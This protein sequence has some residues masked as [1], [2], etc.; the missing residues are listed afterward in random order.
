LFT[1][2]QKV[3]TLLLV[4]V[5]NEAPFQQ[6]GLDFIGEI[7]PHSSAQQ[8]WIL[9]ATEYFSKWVEAIPTRNA[10]DAIVISFLE[11]NILSR[12]GC[13]QKIVTDN[14]QAFNSMSM[15]SFC[16]KYNIVLGHS[17]D[18]YPQGNRLV[19]SSNKIMITII[20]KVLTGNNKSWHVH[21][22]YAL[23]ANK[24]GTKRSIRMSPFRM[25]YG[26]DVILPINLLLPVMKLWKDSQEEP[27]DI[28]RRI[29]QLMEVQ[30]N[31]V[32]VYEKLQRYQ[33][34]MKALFDQKAKDI[35]FLPGDL[36]LKLEARKEDDGKHGKFNQIW[37]GPYKIIAYEG[38]N[39]FLLENLDENI[40]TAPINGRY[41]K[42]FMQ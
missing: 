35:E 37:C 15:I 22:K 25:V 12:F 32:E 26:I 5:K 23:W 42:H 36:V 19:D 20:K 27:N 10:T 13:P 29:N 21:L 1:G 7:H 2:K 14:A 38:K 3:S 11:E 8:K 30:Q 16:K 9:T 4:P 18:Y 34:N 41:L 6:W 39:A 17:M 31:R 33:D 24:I 28:T 40:L